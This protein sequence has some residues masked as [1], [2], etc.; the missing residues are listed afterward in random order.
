MTMQVRFSVTYSIM[1]DGDIIAEGYRT[2]GDEHKARE[3]AADLMRAQSDQLRLF[4]AV[5]QNI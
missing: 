5:T 1:F 3:F 4:I 2:F